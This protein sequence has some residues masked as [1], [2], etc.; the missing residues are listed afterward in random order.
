MG[1]VLSKESTEMAYFSH[2]TLET[3]PKA[4][5]MSPD[6]AAARSVIEEAWPI[7]P[8]RINV[9]AV[10]ADVF[11]AVK[12]VERRLPEDE[13]RRRP[14][15]WTF[16]RVLGIWNKEARRIDNYEMADLE[17]A[18]LEAARHEHSIY[19]EKIQ[20]LASFI[21]ANEKTEDQEL[22]VRLNGFARE[23]DRTGSG[24]AA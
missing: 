6:V 18:A 8:G 7:G 2:G 12:R 3:S 4:N 14:R 21:A 20:R 17:Q 13:L 10:V 5:T 16:R 15:Q 22:A 9:K 19:V 11:D 23:M 1:S 24:A